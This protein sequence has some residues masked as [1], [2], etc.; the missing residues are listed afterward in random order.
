MF[1][2]LFVA[3]V[4][5]MTG[6]CMMMIMNLVQVA[7]GSSEVVCVMQEVQTRDGTLLNGHFN[8]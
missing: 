6:I 3:F 7:L 8:L 4:A 1:V 5:Y 2:C